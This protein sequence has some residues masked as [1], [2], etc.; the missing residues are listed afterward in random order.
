ML[1]KLRN[2]S[3]GFTL[4]ELMIVIAII[5]ILAAIAV[6]QFMT[7]RVRAN[8]TATVALAKQINSSLA[9][10]NS[11]LAAYGILDTTANLQNS[12]GAGTT[13][14]VNNP[15]YGSTQ[16]WSAATA[17]T[18]GCQVTGT[19]YNAAGTE[20]N[21][22]GV[23]QTIPFGIDANIRIDADRGGLDGQQYL[24]VTEHFKGNR[25]IGISSIMPDVLYYV[26]NAAWTGLGSVINATVPDIIPAN[27]ENPLDTAGDDTGVPGGGMPTDH[28]HLMK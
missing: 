14:P 11:D 26:Q 8:N 12:P 23:G 16:A 13:G 2:N 24:L 18:A 1:Q 20:I 6:P 25:A 15:V 17:E 9:A 28:W 7:Y 4:I 22:S 5:G 3:K 10:L 27:E 21:K 19:Y